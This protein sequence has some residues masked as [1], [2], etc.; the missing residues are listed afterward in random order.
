MKLSVAIR[1]SF[2]FEDNERLVKIQKLLK[3][4]GAIAIIEDLEA[5]DGTNVYKLVGENH[6]S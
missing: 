1:V 2:D 5:V 4:L 3:Q 6:E